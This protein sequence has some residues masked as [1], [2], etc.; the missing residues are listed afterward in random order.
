MGNLIQFA[1][2]QKELAGPTADQLKRAFKSFR[3]LT[4]ADAVRLAAGARGILAK[5]LGP[6]AARALQS[7][8]QAEGV[9][10]VIVA[11][12]D[13]PKLPEGLSLNRLELWPQAFTVYDPMGRSI[14]I[15]WQEIRLVAAGAAQGFE[16]NKTQTDHLRLQLNP[17]A[18]VRPRKGDASR[19]RTEPDSQ[20]LLEIFLADS[21]SRYRVE[22]A[23]FRFKYVID[24]PG[25]STEEKFI[26]LVREICRHATHAILNDGARRLREGGETVP[27]YTSRQVLVDEIVWLLWRGAQQQSSHAP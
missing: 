27:T 8:L 23:Q 11:E 12:N 16:I 18:G 4:D 20:L 7:A 1:V 14:A 6:D 17:A 9:G 24:R 5:H 13:L 2:L 22:A 26:W 19:R 15:A 25:L 3:N 10:V 21:A